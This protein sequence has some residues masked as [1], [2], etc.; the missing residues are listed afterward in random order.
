MQA[1][2]S[3]TSSFLRGLKYS[4]NSP[5]IGIHEGNHSSKNGSNVPA[6]APGLLVIVSE[7]SAYGLAD[8]KSAIVGEEN[9]FGRREGIILWE[10]KESM[11]ESELVLFLKVVE[12]EMKVKKIL[13]LKYDWGDRLF[14]DWL[15]FL[16]YS[17]L[18]Y[19]FMVHMRRVE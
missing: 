13:S 15:N 1:F 4:S 18:C 3:Q 9:Y 12:A 5:L 7:S 8:L 2:R 6:R 14:L 10:L 11:V 16:L 17:N 19:F